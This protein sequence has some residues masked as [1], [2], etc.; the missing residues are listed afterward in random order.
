MPCRKGQQAA[1]HTSPHFCQS[2]ALL[3]RR[4]RREEAL[5]AADSMRLARCLAAWRAVSGEEGALRGALARLQHGT[6]VRVLQ[7]WRVGVRCWH[8]MKG[9]ARM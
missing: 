5:S 9:G 3:C 8:C 4:Q 6:A 7:Q 1:F 2:P